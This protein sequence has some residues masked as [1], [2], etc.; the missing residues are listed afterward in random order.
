M[1]RVS[2][3]MTRKMKSDLSEAHGLR[4]MNKIESTVIVADEAA[5]RT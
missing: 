4:K 1:L 2:M 5:S 3:S